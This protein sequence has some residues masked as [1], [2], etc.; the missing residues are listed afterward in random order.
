MNAVSPAKGMG[1]IWSTFLTLPAG[2]RPCPLGPHR[3]LQRGQTYCRAHTCSQVTEV[4]LDGA[5]PPAA[6]AH[7]PWPPFQPTAT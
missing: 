6:P 3:G 7:P 2:G 5:G 4:H 1:T